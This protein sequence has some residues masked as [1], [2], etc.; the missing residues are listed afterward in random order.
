MGDRLHRRSRAA[1]GDPDPRLTTSH[2]SS[3]APR[4]A[5]ACEEIGC[6]SSEVSDPRSLA[7][8]RRLIGSTGTSAGRRSPVEPCE[9]AGPSRQRRL[10][11]GS[12]LSRSMRLERRRSRLRLD[13]PLRRP[14]VPPFGGRLSLVPAFGRMADPN[15]SEGRHVAS[16][17]RRLRAQCR[18]ARPCGQRG[19]RLP[20]RSALGRLKT[21]ASMT[22]ASGRALL[23]PG[24]RPPTRNPPAGP[25]GEGRRGVRRRADREG[26]DAAVTQSLRQTRKRS[27]KAAITLAR[28]EGAPSGSPGR[29]TGPPKS[30]VRV[31]ART[32]RITPRP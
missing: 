6:G 12:G 14:L 4:L 13:R 21:P 23:C 27:V 11:G 24:R 26:R 2:N 18:G 7:H 29:R 3:V 1:P 30:R 25:R 8:R 17:P 10:I 22:I 28:R 16:S 19:G 31:G 5:G 9:W 32:A 15:H 20:D